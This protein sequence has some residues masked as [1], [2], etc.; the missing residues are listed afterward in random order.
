MTGVVPQINWLALGPHVLVV[1]T[2]FIVMFVDLA[3]FRR[4]DYSNLVATN[5]I[6]LFGLL[7]TLG[8]LL[9]VWSQAGDPGSMTT[10]YGSVVLDRFA[11]FFDI[12]FVVA[13]IMTVLFS[14]Q[15]GR[16]E[17]FNHGEFYTLLL[18]AIYGMMVMTST[19]NLLMVFLGLELMSLAVYVLAGQ[20][21]GQVKSGEAA[22]K[23][24]LLGAFSTGFLLFGMA[25][26]FG[27][28]GSLDITQIGLPE[29]AT[30]LQTTLALGGVG[31]LLVGFG[32]KTASVPFHMWTPDVYDGAPTTVTGFMAVGVKAAAF[33]AFLRVF[34]QALFAINLPW[35]KVLW[36]IAILTMTYGNLVALVQTN[37]KRM[38]AYSSIA[39][40]GYILVGL[41]ALFRSK[42]FGAEGIAYYL[43]A[44]AFMNLG[45][46]GVIAYLAKKGDTEYSINSYAGLSAR[47]PVLAAS[48]AIF[49]FSLA[50]IP[51]FGGFFAKFYVF[52][53]GIK[54]GLYW[55]VIA[56][57]LNS[58]LSVYY[59]I[60][61]VYLMYMKEAEEGVYAAAVSNPNFASGL[62][63][64]VTAAFTIILGVLPQTFAT[65]AKSSIANIFNF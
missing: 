40:A 50:G 33:A 63:V 12:L 22:L 4:R 26:I 53:A 38:L 29:N 30:K 60:R 27:A 48:L 61:V 6:A 15:Y 51:P 42:E 10:L 23:Y 5:M 11:I 44:Y 13:G 21:R 19:N 36:V 14:W 41:V 17:G 16:L 64:L 25:G 28:S 1:I 37:I 39:H 56:G 20:I 43:L 7:V 34:G 49:L 57:V 59:Y 35:T 18:F 24:F 9:S 31:L 8:Y 55:L 46:F 32:F 45:A 47:H 3:I 65:F 52:S 2:A 62:G 58:M 54:A